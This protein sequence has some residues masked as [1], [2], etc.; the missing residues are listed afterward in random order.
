MR[1][2][3][4]ESAGRAASRAASQSASQP[5]SQPERGWDIAV[6]GQEE[7]DNSTAS[8]MLGPEGRERNQ[9]P[10]SREEAERRAEET[11]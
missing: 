9:N 5:A 6:K 2:H 7:V 3:R 4:R 1:L 10:A 11:D 8:G